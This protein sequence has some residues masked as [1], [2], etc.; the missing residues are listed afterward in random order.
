MEHN[1]H[2]LPEQ[3]ASKIAAG[4]VV[5]RPASVVKE[6]IENAIDAQATSI[7]VII[8]EGGKSFIQVFDNGIGMSEEDA[9]TAFG[10]HATSKISTLE[11]LES[12]RTLGFRG[13]AL[14]SIA[15]IARVEMRTRREA[16]EV[17]TVLRIDG[18]AMKPCTKQACE[19]GTSVTVRNLFFN[20]P[21]RRNFLKA[22][23][24]EFRHIFDVV[25]RNA[26]AHPQI[27]FK[28]ISDD[29]VVLDLQPD[30]LSGRVREVF[31]ESEFDGLVPFDEKTETL[32][33]SGYVGMP[34]FAKRTRSEQYL[35]LNSRYILSRSLNYAVY[36]AYEHTLE[37]GSFPLSIVFITLD[38][39][40]VD[41]NV[42]PSKLE[43]KF[44]DERSVYR[45][46]HGAV[47]KS[48][49]AHDL[50]PTISM[51]ENGSATGATNL[52]FTPSPTAY[53]WQDLFTD[54]P[55]AAVSAASQQRESL[56]G[57]SSQPAASAQV[58]HPAQVP[59]WQIHNKYILVPTPE[60]LIVIDQH[61]AH[62]RILYDRVVERLALGKH[63]SQ[64]LLF[65]HTSELSAGDA[66]LVQQL[67]PHL[68]G[69]GFQLKLFGK[70][71]VVVEGV[72]ADV[73]SGHEATI[74]REVIDLYKENE[75]DVKL[76]PRENLAKSYSCK[77]AVKAGNALSSA[78]IHSLLDQLFKT[79]VPFVCPHGRPVLV[80]IPLAELDRRFGRSV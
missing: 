27:H 56:P 29:E 42:H 77:A 38:P 26:L 67:L 36:Q 63:D 37:K 1:V 68:E 78:E 2:I 50:I 18:G 35:F 23:N 20:T 54:K 32:S 5:Q 33:V 19:R 59:A 43:V 10:R 11:D 55:P 64:Q 25:Q 66:A 22:I 7:T 75:H 74:L 46:I 61:A 14:Y 62:E 16:D 41:V 79:R 72:P 31:G 13:E 48:L 76:E 8:K 69:M 17:G 60:G 73:R 70:N 51:T 34:Q 15:A 12:I 57:V 40:R 80:R 3:I 53:R 58:G 39:R 71:T 28:F 6:L 4:E 65:P 44:E 47:R 45:L 24:T 21:A 49:M 9:R 30:E 52:G